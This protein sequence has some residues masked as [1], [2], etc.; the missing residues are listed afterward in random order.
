MKWKDK[1]IDAERKV[2][3]YEI[4]MKNLADE[5]ISMKGTI[6]Q[7]ELGISKLQRKIEDL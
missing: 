4:K 5:N 1:Y 3:G 7:M 2:D 6:K